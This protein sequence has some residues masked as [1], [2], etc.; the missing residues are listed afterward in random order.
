MKSLIGLGLA[1]ALAAVFAPPSP[2]PGA[3]AP[4]RVAFIVDSWYPWSHADVIGTR[5]L[6]GYRV[7]DRSYAS[8]VTI[9]SVYA[10]APAAR[11]QTR[12][13]AS[14]Y[15]FRAASSIADALLDDAQRPAPRLTAD[16]VLIATREDLP[17]SGQRQ[18][19]MRRVQVVREV[20]AI[21]DRT[22]VRVPVFLDKMLAAD[23]ADSQAIVVEAA[24]RNVPLM[25]G[26]VLP[27][28]PLDRPLRAGRPEVGVVVAS[29][30]YWAFA[31]H[32]A[33]LLQGFLEQRAA[34]ETGIH[35]IR[36]VGAGYASLP[37][38]DRWGG[39]VFD[40]LLASARTRRRPGRP[41]ADALLIRYADGTR[42]VLALVPEAFDDS[43]FLLGAQ[44]ADGTIAT[45]G[46][47]LGG[48]PYDHFGYLVHALVEFFTTGRPP[49]PVERTLLTTGIVL[50]GRQSAQN[51]AAVFPP[52]AIPYIPPRRSH[53]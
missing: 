38:R 17:E 10:D 21:L 34:R 42:A 49:V 24:R 39:A 52:L 28:A 30:P 29:T 33:E 47:V 14:R 5:F 9:A 43:E 37:D 19:P 13:L 35:E 15:G 32:A 48:Q 2:A 20:L 8:P 36:N 51:G 40:A 45:G 1:A 12:A 44:Y 31:F 18:S 53:P 3:P 27:F 50:F 23:W 11:D 41:P 26:S 25:A 4:R 46:L 16:G 22:G 6:Q 7:G